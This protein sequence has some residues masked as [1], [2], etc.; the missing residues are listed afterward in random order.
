MSLIQA[1]KYIDIKWNSNT[2]KG[3]E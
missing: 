1:H 3:F 2:G